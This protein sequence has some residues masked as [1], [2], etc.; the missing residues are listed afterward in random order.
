MGNSLCRALSSYNVTVNTIAPGLFPS[1][2][3]KFMVENDSIREAL[4]EANPLKRLGEASD[5]AGTTLYLCSKAGRFTNGAVI[6]LDGGQYLHDS[7]I[8]PKL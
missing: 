1:K 4:I 5:I 7:A 8:M 2:M 3:S 6:A